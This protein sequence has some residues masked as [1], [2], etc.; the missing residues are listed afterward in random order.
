M[1]SWLAAILCL[2]AFLLNLDLNPFIGDE[3]IRSLVALEMMLSKNYLV[4]TMKG[5]FYFSK[6]PLYNW[7]LIVFF[8]LFGRISEFTARVPTVIFSFLFTYLIYFFN[9]KRF[10][11]PTFSVILAFMFL[12]CGRMIFYDSFL[13][14]IDIFFSM[15]TYAMIIA[16][17]DQAEKGTFNRMY[18]IIYFLSVLGFML[19]GFPT[20]HFLVFTLLIIHSQFGNWR[21]LFSSFHLFSILGAIGI[22][23]LYFF[24]YNYYREATH[25]LNPLLDQATRRTIL[26]FG[27]TDLVKH[28]ISYPFENIYHFFPWTLMGLL[29]FRKDIIILLKKDKYI[30]YL[31]YSFIANF[32]IYW[33]SPEVYPRYILM[34][35]PIIFSV[36]VYL[37]GFEL[38][39]DN[40]RMKLIAWIFKIIVIVIP[41]IILSQYDNVQLKH[42]NDGLLK[43]LLLVLV[44]LFFAYLYFKDRV[45]RPMVFVVYIL[46]L[47]IGFNALVLP[48]R[49]ETG[50]DEVYK[51][52]A[53]RIGISYK[54]IKLYDT[55]DLNHITA[56]YI[57]NNTKRI[58][59]RTKDLKQA[60]YFIIDSSYMHQFPLIDS[61]PDASYCGTRWVI[62]GE[63]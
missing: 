50:D 56:F 1:Y 49:A 45:N 47:R 48:V 44:L 11:N 15:V 40:L 10:T 16:A 2:P 4:P 17:Y 18:V 29:V 46:I 5:D 8:R 41:I 32:F 43:L 59:N 33:I 6:P 19:K 31:V 57:T 20:V 60:E 34:L 58:T 30:L 28:F 12:T 52:E 14:L 63:K 36:W 3:A 27:F 22:I 26:K 42:V 39:Q 13:G 25:T 24:L 55:T 21:K 61:F 37:Y 35:I 62:K 53:S 23:G 38:G 7:I 9:K 54:D 51:R